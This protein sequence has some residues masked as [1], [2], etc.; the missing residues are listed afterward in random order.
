MAMPSFFNIKKIMF[1]A[2]LCPAMGILW[3]NY[4]YITKIILM[5]I[6]GSNDFYFSTLFPFSDREI[7]AGT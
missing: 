2:A 7:M 5:M 4:V 1:A 3:S 6:S